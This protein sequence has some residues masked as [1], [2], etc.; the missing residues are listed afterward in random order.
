MDANRREPAL[1]VQEAEGQ[2]LL[3]SVFQE[4]GCGCAAS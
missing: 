1:L 3:G 4:F 2:V